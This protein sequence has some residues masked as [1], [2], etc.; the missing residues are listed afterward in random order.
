MGARG[1]AKR[2]TLKIS[3]FVGIPI[4]VGH[5]CLFVVFSSR[6]VFRGFLRGGFGPVPLLQVKAKTNA[7]STRLVG[8]IYVP[9]CVVFFSAQKRRVSRAIGVGFRKVRR[10]K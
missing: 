5:L 9:V 8:V 3:C 2:D 7:V 6:V 1:I 4:I 10:E